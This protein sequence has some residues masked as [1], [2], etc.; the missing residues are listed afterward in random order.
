MDRP[1]IEPLRT[2]RKLSFL[3]DRQLDDLQEATLQILENTGI[4]FP[5]EKALKIFADHGAI[6]DQESQ[7]VKIPRGLVFKA[8]A[9]LPRYFKLG[10]RNP[11]FD[12]DLQEGV[13]YFTNDGCGHNVI[14]LIDRR[15][16]GFQKIRCWHDGPDQ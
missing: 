7:I 12:L 11:E 14:D 3:D 9:T 2:S 6:V 13:S 4:Q 16:A 5:S 8:M 1:P 10:A 15:N